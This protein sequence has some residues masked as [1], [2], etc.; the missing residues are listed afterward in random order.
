LS[1]SSAAAAAIGNAQR[2]AMSVFMP[3]SIAQTR[4]RAIALTI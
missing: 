3:R 4:A 2:M 1:S